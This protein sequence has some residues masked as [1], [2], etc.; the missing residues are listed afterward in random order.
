MAVLITSW[1]LG[2]AKPNLKVLFN[3]SFIVLGVVIASFGEVQFVFVGFLF[4]LGGI[5]FEAIRLVLVQK[6]LSSEEFKMD[7]LVSLYYYAP[8]CAIMNFA[9]SVF[10]ELPR[11]HLSQIVD[12][13]LWTLLANA[14][15]AFCLN[16]SVVF[17]VSLPLELSDSTA[18]STDWQNLFPRLYALWRAQGYPAGGRFDAHL[19]R[20]RIPASILRLQYRSGWPCLLQA[21]SRADHR[22]SQQ[23]WPGMGRVRSETSGRTQ[24]GHWWDGRFHIARGS[25]PPHSWWIHVLHWKYPDIPSKFKKSRRHLMGSCMCFDGRSFDCRAQTVNWS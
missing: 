22:A 17:L 20:P 1:A 14:M 24:A 2:V 16:V 15:V 19:G 4:Q 12:T 5:V 13:G 3:V 9:V 21:W 8:V 18:D 10:T 23:R 7:P 6:I 25:P 11:L